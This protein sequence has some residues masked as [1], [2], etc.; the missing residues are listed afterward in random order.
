MKLIKNKLIILGIILVTLCL[1]YIMTRPVYPKI[2]WLYWDS[3]PLPHTINLIK[4]YNKDKMKDWDVKYL[5]IHTIKNYIPDSAY[6]TKYN[7]LVPANKS[8]WIRLYI[9]Y[10]YGG[11]WMDAGIIVNNS[12][13]L[14][15][16]YDKSLA[17][18]VQM[19]VFKTVNED[20]VFKHSS[21]VEVPLVI[22]SWFI[23]SPK[24][25]PIIKAWLDDFTDAIQI[26]FLNYKR[27]IVKNGTDIS[28]IHCGNEE[29]T[30]LMVHMCIQN[31]IQKKLNKVPKM[32]ILDSN[33]SM[34]RI[35][36]MCG[37]DDKC[38]ADKLNN[39]KMCKQLPFIKLI[40]SNRR[41]NIDKYFN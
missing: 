29:D 3:E 20:G 15:Y 7:D 40:N 31:V 21:G 10:T 16:I 9:L 32:L 39:D 23:L 12:D 35:Q 6:N 37:W 25:S 41:E 19:A 13:A 1:A 34:F 36:N 24:G 4:Q 17:N 5:N 33:D 11:L 26:G 27:Q 18:N 14:N 22:D 30:Y 8:D 38:I 2:I 28:K